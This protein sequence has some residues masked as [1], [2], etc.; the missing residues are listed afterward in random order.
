MKVMFCAN[1]M[2]HGRIC[3][4]DGRRSAGGGVRRRIVTQKSPGEGDDEAKN[5]RKTRQVPRISR[6]KNSRLMFQPP[7]LSN[8]RFSGGTPRLS[9]M[10]STAFDMGPGPHM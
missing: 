5:M 7:K 1:R 4:D 3:R 2:Y 9:S 10:P 6:R 8:M